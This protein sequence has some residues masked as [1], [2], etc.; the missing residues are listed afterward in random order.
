MQLK[1]HKISK[2]EL[3]FGVGVLQTQPKEYFRLCLVREKKLDFG[4]LNLLQNV[5]IYSPS[6]LFY[7]RSFSET[8]Y[9]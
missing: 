8:R 3:F 2:V 1:N 7:V 5:C 9:H 6:L 4:S